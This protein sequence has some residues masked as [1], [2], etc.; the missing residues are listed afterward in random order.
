MRKSILVIAL[1]AFSITGFS[2]TADEIITNHLD[3]MGGLD[4]WS[5]VEGV[6]M[7]ISVDAQGM[8]IGGYI[9]YMSDGREYTTYEFQGQSIPSGFDGNEAW[10]TNFM[11]MKAERSDDETTENAKRSVGEFPSPFLNYERKGFSVELMEDD[12]A[13]GVDCYK[14]KLTKKPMLIDGEETENVV[15]HYF[16]KETF[17]L[18]MDEQTIPSGEMAGMVAQTV[19]S[20]Y[21][22]VDGLYFPFSMT[23][24]IKDGEGQTVTITDIEL[25]PEVDDSLFA[26]PG[27]AETTDAETDSE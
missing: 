25:N 11:T 20:D 12:I 8:T 6:K 21:D 3:V 15:Y 19:Y 18:I 17:A 4:A 26:Y 2:Q 13:E 22:E 9:I 10:E 27:D 1:S 16:D 5:A 14:I 24:R 7:G 23:S